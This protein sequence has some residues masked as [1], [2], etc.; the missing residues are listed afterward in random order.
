MVDGVNNTPK[1]AT[2]YSKLNLKGLNN[3]IDVNKLAG[4]KKTTGNEALFK[5]Y[6]K[7]GNGVIDD[8]EAIAM[9]NNL[10]SLAGD[11]TISKNELSTLFGKNSNALEQLNKLA[12]QQAAIRDG[13]EYVE[14]NG[15]TTTHLGSDYSYT[16]TRREDGSEL[17]VLD[18]GS[19][20]IRHKNG[21]K[22]ILDKNGRVTTYDSQGNKRIVS[23]PDGTKITF[24]P[25]GNKSETTNNKGEVIGTQE[26]KGDTLIRTAVERQN[27]QKITREYT[28]K[29]DGSNEALSSIVVSGREKDETGK[30]SN[31]EIKY[32]SEED[33]KNNRPAS[34]I[35]N[36]G[37]ST[38]TTISYEYDS[39]GNQK[40]IE[41]DL[42]KKTVTR[43]QNSEGKPLHAAEFNSTQSKPIETGTTISKIVKNALAEQGITNPSP[44]Q[45]KDA[46]KQFIELN[47]D[48]IKTYNGTKTQLKGNKY[49]LAGG[50]VVIPNYKES[51]PNVLQSVEVVGN[52]NHSEEMVA[53]R[54][55]LQADVGDGFEVRYS[56]DGKS[57]EVYDKNG[58]IDE[59]LTRRANGQETDDDDINV[60]MES[61][62]DG[63]NSLDIKEYTD[64]VFEWLKNIDLKVPESHKLEV[65]QL[66]RESFT[67]LDTINQ[68]MA[69]TKEE[70]TKN[71]KDILNQLIDKIKDLKDQPNSYDKLG[72]STS[73]EL[74]PNEN[75]F[76]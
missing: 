9:R 47:K 19:K 35:K 15:D 69:V 8:K 28:D 56:K 33:L 73:R 23:N 70:L 49:M 67:S 59:V 68:D 57:F 48:N 26:L 1:T 65:T 32:N 64:F 40:I 71:A 63:S 4:L 17:L 76:G 38:E 25:D 6:D 30:T 27:G 66:I 29:M 45:L 54:K 58:E 11:G 31:I 5:M 37:L 14:T 51:M 36:K 46:T 44:D 18:D 12:N 34:A 55:E 43:Y 2:Q 20:E 53:K 52:K 16:L 3:N 41:T 42:A 61:D 74:G 62:Q 72:D 50:N 7:D 10:Q 39:T 60:M 22:Q 13:I 75:S 21:S 24:T